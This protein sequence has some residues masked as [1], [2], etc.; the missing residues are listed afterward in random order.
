MSVIECADLQTIS[1]YLQ[2]YAPELKVLRKLSHNWAKQSTSELW[3]RKNCQCTCRKGRY[4]VTMVKR[5]FLFFIFYVGGGLIYGTTF[6]SGVFHIC[7]LYLKNEEWDKTSKQ[8]SCSKMPFYYLT[9]IKT[10]GVFHNSGPL[11]LLRLKNTWEGAL[12]SVDLLKIT[13]LQHP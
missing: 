10:R 7:Y 6:V 4:F 5:F 3:Q 8:C 9:A 2:S 13:L 1:D 11:A 12:I